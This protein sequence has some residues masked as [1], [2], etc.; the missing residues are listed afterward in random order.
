MAYNPTQMAQRN[1]HYASTV[2][3]VH[4]SN[5]DELFPTGL[6]QYHVKIPADDL[7]ATPLPE[8]QGRVTK[9]Q[10]TCT[11]TAD[12]TLLVPHFLLS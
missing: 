11:T 4:F 8:P 3:P 9:A 1:V 12:L 2:V 10:C 6:T 5:V 7:P